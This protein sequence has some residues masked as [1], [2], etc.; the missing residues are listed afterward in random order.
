MKSDRTEDEAQLIDIQKGLSILKNVNWDFSQSRLTTPNRIY[1]FDCRH[2]HWYPATFIPEIPFTLIEVLTKPNATVFDPFGGIGTT[3]FQSLLLE[4]SPITTEICSVAVNYM[5]SLFNLFNPEIK[6]S[7][8][9]N[10]LDVLLNSYNKNINYISDLPDNILIERLTPW[11]SENTLNQIAFLCSELQHIEQNEIL[12]PLLEISISAN[13]KSSS[14]QDRGWGC[15]ADNVTPK[16]NQIQDKNYI[17]NVHDHS[18]RMTNDIIK[19]V[20]L[21][22]KSYPIFYN[23]LSHDLK[24]YHSDIR[25]AS[26][27][28]DSSIDLLITSPPYPNM[29][30]YV[31]SQRLSYYLFGFEVNPSDIKSTPDFEMEIGARRKRFS[32]TSLDKYEKEMKEANLSISKQMKN[33]GLACFVL[34]EFNKDNTN[35]K[36][37]KK[38]ISQIISHLEEECDFEKKGEFIRVLPTKRRHHN[39]KWASLDKEKIYIFQRK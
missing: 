23:K 37:R 34:P 6:W 5:K 29:A 21:L 32:N 7:S 3:Y 18:K 12:K 20:N 30:D 36:N 15:I 10:D 13:L 24:I 1:P 39:Q 35:N 14:S 17:K 4:R 31:T 26:M 9:I 19:H 22:T 38:I 27:I 28:P 11:Y 33:G 8:V 16:E 2:Y 25:K